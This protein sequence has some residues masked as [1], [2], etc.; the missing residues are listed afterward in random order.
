MSGG[1]Y[2]TSKLQCPEAPKLGEKQ[3][4]T[5]QRGEGCGGGC[6]EEIVEQARGLPAA[7]AVLAPVEVRDQKGE[8]AIV[9]VQKVLGT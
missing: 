9:L 6:A 1:Q 4:L 2:S 7:V 8:D 3:R 5:Q